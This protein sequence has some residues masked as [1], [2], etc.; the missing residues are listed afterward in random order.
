M[1]VAQRECNAAEGR[2]LAGEEWGRS[3]DA[4]G[5]RDATSVAMR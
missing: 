3:W 4:V 5:G 2:S 1:N